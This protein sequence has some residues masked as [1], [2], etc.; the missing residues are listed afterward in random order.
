MS[1][2]GGQ[3]QGLIQGLG[4]QRPVV[5]MAPSPQAQI[6]PW[7]QQATAPPTPMPTWAQMK[8]NWGWG[9]ND[10][11]SVGGAT[12]ADEGGMVPPEGDGS[13]GDGGGIMG[14]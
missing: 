8:K 1:G 10:E 2:Q 4:Q 14:A 6:Q 7:Q 9:A 5:M 3:P 12:T 13:S 11:S